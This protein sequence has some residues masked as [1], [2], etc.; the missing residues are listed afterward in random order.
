M[1]GVMLAV[2]LSLASPLAAN[3]ASPVAA[4]DSYDTPANVTLVVDAAAGLL[5]NDTDTDAD[6]LNAILVTGP[7]S[8]GLTLNPDGSFS[9]FPSIG[10]SGTV[11]F[12]YRAGDS[13]TTSNLATVTITVVNAAP[14]AYDDTY[15][16][17][18]VVSIAV[19]PP[20]VLANDTDTFG[21]DFS[22]V[23]VAGPTN[24][25]LVGFSPSGLFNYIPNVGFNGSDT[26][27]YRVD[28]GGASNNLSNIATVT[29]DVIASSNPAPVAADDSYS[30]STGGALDVDAAAG[31]LI[32]DSDVYDPIYATLTSGPANGG[33]TLYAHGGF[34]YTPFSGFSGIDSFTY[35]AS[36]GVNFSN[37]ATVT[38]NVIANAAPVATD[39]SYSTP[40]GVT[41]FITNPLNSV[42]NDD[43]DAD[44]DP[45]AAVL[46]TGPAHGSLTLNADGTFTYTPAS[47]FS[48]SDS[49]S[50]R[51]SDGTAS[52]NAATV[53]ITVNAA[54]VAT[55][56]SYSTPSDVQL[57]VAAA[58]GVLSN[59]TDT[60]LIVAVLNTNP[61]SGALT[62]N[63][64]GSFRYLP[65]PG[66]GGT[67]TFTY[68][69]S[70]GSAF[71]NL[72]TVTIT[73]TP[74]A[75]V[76]GSEVPGSGLMAATGSDSVGTLVAVTLGLTL[77]GSV[78][79]LV[80]H[81]RRTDADAA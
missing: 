29:I 79:V 34:T 38:L 8:G 62:L 56:D 57:D 51:A 65:A 12:T 67:V 18:S 60:D 30:T 20:G 54:P 25:T 17:A 59:D 81:R 64:D 49:F 15:A 23:L 53:T 9:Y 42:L 10:F 31:L 1:F 48:G 46:A 47:G 71:S 44:G 3:A 27:T 39:D 35:Q 43:T 37:V 16:S 33:I 13:T 32:N 5:S 63:G 66:Y 75:D 58:A 2:G 50:Y 74:A 76:P 68:W 7:A 36:D 26:F 78:L 55:S 72:V 69:A 11:D 6:P 19:G 77:L 52:S 61:A 40:A 70:D 4:D 28:D 73:V 24:G 45:L 41:L 21:D 14:V 80:H 22:A